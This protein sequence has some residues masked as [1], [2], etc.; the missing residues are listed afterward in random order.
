[1]IG[2]DEFD[3]RPEP[4][5]GSGHALEEFL[6]IRPTEIQKVEYE[7]KELQRHDSYDDKDSEIEEQVEQIFKK[8]MSGYLNLESVLDGVEPK[9][10]ARLAEV[11]LQYLKTGLDAANSK[12]K[13]KDSIEKVKAKERAL[14]AGGKT[15]NNIIFSGD[16]N[17]FLRQMREVMK[18][19]DAIEGEVVDDE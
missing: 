6:N 1:M 18:K 15:T 7:G 16:R 2:D 12:A 8:A 11:A 3:E 9:Y 4:K 19:S 5:K 13:Q 14:D 10:R 17:D